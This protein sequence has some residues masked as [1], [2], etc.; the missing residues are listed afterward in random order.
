MNN[1]MPINVIPLMEWTDKTKKKKNLNQK[2]RNN[3]IVLISTKKFN[4]L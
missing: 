2:E 1:C 4:V 3:I